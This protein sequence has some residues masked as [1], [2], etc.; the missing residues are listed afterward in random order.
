MEKY[1]PTLTRLGLIVIVWLGIISLTLNYSLKRD[2]N[3]EFPYYQAELT[4]HYSRA[5]SVFAHFDGIHY[6]RIARYGY[7][8]TGTQ[9]FFPVYPLMIRALTPITP[10]PLF[11][12][13]MISII[14]LIFAIFGIYRLF[15]HHKLLAIGCMLFFPTSFYFLGV[16]SESL[17]LALSIW[18][19]Y[20][21]KKK[22]WLAA[23]ILA[24]I[25]SGTRVIGCLLSLSLLVEMILHA[26]ESGHK[27][28]I[29][30]IFGLLAIS[31][32]GLMLYMGY[33]Y[34]DFADPLMFMRVLPMFGVDRYDSRLITLPQVIYRYLKILLTVEPASWVYFRSLLEL[35]SLAAFGSILAIGYK[36]IPFSQLIFALGALL[37]PTL[38]G[39]LT[40][41]PRY[42]L[43]IFPVYYILARKLSKR[44]LFLMQLISLLGL[45]SLFPLFAIGR[46][47]A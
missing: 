7:Q 23:A 35:F 11:A 34:R 22:H 19:F 8:D 43:V 6:L 20:M 1:L 4:S 30:R 46:F 16:Y 5:S 12:G 2:L 38:T 28:K 3:I 25:A 18:F 40:S 17:F 29:F 24:G 9:A 13:V 44:N 10:S 31:L 14:T 47:V 26:K 42:V 45:I 36:L 21:V 39:S 33:L 27:I 41:L 37:I 15:P 32:S